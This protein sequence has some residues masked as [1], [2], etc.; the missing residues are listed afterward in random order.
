M[1]ETSNH[2]LIIFNQFITFLLKSSNFVFFKIKIRIYLF[3]VDLRILQ[4]ILVNFIC[5]AQKT[6]RNSSKKLSLKIY[7]TKKNGGRDLTFGT[8]LTFGPDW[9]WNMTDLKILASSS[10]NKKRLNLIRINLTRN[11]NQIRVQ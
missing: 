10:S 3:R 1:S 6:E 11:L 2:K 9:N 5:S 8:D 7:I 4:V